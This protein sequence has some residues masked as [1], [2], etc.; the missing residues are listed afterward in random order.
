M[1]VEENLSTFKNETQENARFYGQDE[2]QRGQKGPSETKG[3]GEKAAYRI[4]MEKGKN[5]WQTMVN[6]T[7]YPE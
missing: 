1:T 2:H 7:I 4:N 6:E 3:Q 5:P